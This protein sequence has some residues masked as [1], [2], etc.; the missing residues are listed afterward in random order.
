MRI[1][2]PGTPASTPASSRRLV[3]EL[4]QSMTSSGSESLGGGVTTTSLPSSRIRAPSRS[5][6]FHVE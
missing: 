2:S 5:T 4:P 1:E 6:A 3:P